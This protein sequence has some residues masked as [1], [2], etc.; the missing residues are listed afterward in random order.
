MT[1]LQNINYKDVKRLRILK[2]FGD[3][4]EDD[5]FL[6]RLLLESR[7]FNGAMCKSNI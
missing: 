4:S 1:S 7:D 5:F 2:L 6:T 3:L